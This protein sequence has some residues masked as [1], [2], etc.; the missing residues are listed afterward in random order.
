MATQTQ[1]LAAAIPRIETA[2]LVLRSPRI[3]DFDAWAAFAD[4][5][6]AVIRFDNDAI[7][8]FYRR[9]IQIPQNSGKRP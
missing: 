6:V 5:P 2:R 7:P 3:E 4:D 9:D 8:T 1:S